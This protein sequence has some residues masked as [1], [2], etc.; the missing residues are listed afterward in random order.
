MKVTTVGRKINLRNNF[1][2]KVEKRMAKFDR[3]FDDDNATATVTA[4]VEKERHTAEITLKS[5]GFYY[6]SE[7]TESSLEAAFNN[8]ADIL[9]KQI[10]KNKEKLGARVKKGLL[11]ADAAQL[12]ADTFTVVREKTFVVEAMSAEEAAL[13]MDMLSH[14]FYMFKNDETGLINV[15]YR[16]HDG[17]YGVLIPL[18]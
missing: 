2:E 4:T 3:Y 10:V 15:V 13:R 17:N 9:L 8:A 12:A 1:I 6:R 5:R 18:D 11:E 16:R 14:N 7:C